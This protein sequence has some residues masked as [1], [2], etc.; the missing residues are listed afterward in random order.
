MKEW[1]KRKTAVISLLLIL[2]PAVFDMTIRIS[3]Y[4]G[5]DRV[6]TIDKKSGKRGELSSKINNLDKTQQAS[7]EMLINC[8]YYAP[9]AHSL[10][11]EHQEED[12]ERMA[13]LGTDIVSFSVRDDE[14]FN[15]NQ[16]RIINFINLA[17]KHNLK[18]HV[19]PSSFGELTAGWIVGPSSWLLNNPD[20]WMKPTV[21]RAD[22]ANKK[23]N[24]YAKSVLKYLVVD[25]KVDGII[26]DEPRP[27]RRRDVFSFLDNMSA[28]CKVLDPDI[29]I[30]IFAEAGCLHLADWFCEMQ[31]IDYFG[32]DGHLRSNDHKMHRMKNTILKHIA[33]FTLN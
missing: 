23:W 17:H 24:R 1:M 2:L 4:S 22:P 9:H 14:L 11:I 28:Y 16:Q 27:S 8:Y 6:Q 15:W 20:V 31:Y 29:K 32:A 26:W 19:I 5:D 25:L 13:E 3:A 12:L 18:V 33:C 30:S 21:V 10:L 7:E